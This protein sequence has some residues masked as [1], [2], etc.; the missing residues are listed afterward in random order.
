LTS[1]MSANDDSSDGDDGDG[2][3]DHR[4]DDDALTRRRDELRRRNDDDGATN[5][6]SVNNDITGHHP[7]HVR[8]KHR[9]RSDRERAAER[10]RGG[11]G[12]A[13]AVV[14]VRLEDTTRGRGASARRV[15]RTTGHVTSARTRADDDDND[16]DDDDNDMTGGEIRQGSG[17]HPAGHPAVTRIDYSRISGLQ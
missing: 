6:A 13:A 15:R 3:G 17:R 10:R 14:E 9:V 8:Q 16:C 11:S 1:Q 7:Q 12:R 5:V 2:D 4:R